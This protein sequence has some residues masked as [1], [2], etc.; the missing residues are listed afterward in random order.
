MG[1]A[2]GAARGDRP[3]HRRRCG[4]RS[5]PVARDAHHRAYR[6][7]GRGGRHDGTAPRPREGPRCRRPHRPHYGAP[8]HDVRG[9][10]GTRTGSRRRAHRMGRVDIA[11]LDDGPSRGGGTAPRPDGPLS[12]NDHSS[13]PPLRRHRKRP[14][15]RGH[16]R[17]R[18]RAHR[19]DAELA[20]GTAL[21]RRRST[22]D[23]LP[24]RR[25]T[26]RRPR[27]TPSGAAPPDHHDRHDHER[28]RC[29][30]HDD[31]ARRRT[32]R[33]PRWTA[34][35]APP[36]RARH[37]RRSRDLCHQR[38]PR[39]A[40][41]RPH[42][43][44]HHDHRQPDHPHRRRGSPR[45]GAQLVG[46]GRLHR[47]PLHPHARLSA[48]PRR[49]QHPHPQRYRLHAARRHRRR[50]WTLAQP[51]P[52]HWRLRHGSPL[53]HTRRRVGHGSERL[54]GCRADHLPHRRTARRD[55]R[56]HISA[57][58]PLPPAPRQTTPRKEQP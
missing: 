17:V 8:R 56:R 27:P 14:P 57:S 55:R 15:R 32:L 30:G 5:R 44:T 35:T 42:L 49:Q 2:P 52:H 4:L 23:R 41:R 36:R 18:P 22:S 6:P 21:G 33:P 50:T 10:H 58:I 31:H 39:R 7:G 37:G 19:A 26:R 3:L 54:I 11:L 29:H 34:A 16:R 25:A 1:S 9:R 24:R 40:T 38:R 12:A 28:P 48:L 43:T 46:R 45:H 13:A 47:R 51:R 53:R 20:D